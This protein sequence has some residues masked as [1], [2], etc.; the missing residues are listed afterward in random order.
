MA[1]QQLIDYITKARVAGQSDDQTSS[2]LYKNGWTEVEVKEALAALAQPKPQPQP[3]VVPQTEV[4][5]VSPVVDNPVVETNTQVVSQP[6]QELQPEPQ[7]NIQQQPAQPEAQPEINKVLEAQIQSDRFQAQPLT[8]AV[9]DSMPMMK[10]KSHAILMS[11]S[12]ISF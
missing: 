9:E 3:Q 4:S 2:L 8:T 12:S 5:P 6:K 10:H 1:E 11:D 7:I